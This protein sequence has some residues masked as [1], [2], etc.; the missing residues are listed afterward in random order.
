MLLLASVAAKSLTVPHEA[1]D[2]AQQRRQPAPGA[3]ALGATV[4][5]WLCQAL[6]PAE[7]T[8]AAV[9]SGPAAQRNDARRR[10][11][12]VGGRY[13]ALA[14]EAAA[15]AVR[16]EAKAATRALG[17]VRRVL[18]EG[19]ALQPLQPQQAAAAA[20]VVAAGGAGLVARSLLQ[21]VAAAAAR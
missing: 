15:Q 8:A 16:E 5:L 14:Q 20:A 1:S 12:A 10:G 7:V 21:T 13:G 4:L 11:G 17:V 18:D 2:G 3:S 19:R 6:A 9:A